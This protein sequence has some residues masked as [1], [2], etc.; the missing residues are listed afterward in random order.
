MKKGSA[1]AKAWGRRMRA[2]RTGIVK[3]VRRRRMSRS[4]KRRTG[5]FRMARRS[6]RVSHRRGMLGG[7]GV[8]SLAKSALIG[9]GTAHFAGYIPVSIP[10]KEEAAGAVG[11]YLIGGKNIKSA[12]VGAAAVYLAKMLANNGTGV[13]GGN[14]A[15]GF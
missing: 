10:F 4:V 11:A 8:S 3:K 5:V 12:A 7:S 15:Y 6:K 2:L 1:A 13:S 14:S 9:V